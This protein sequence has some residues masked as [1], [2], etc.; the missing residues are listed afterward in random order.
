MVTQQPVLR[1]RGSEGSKH[2]LDTGPRPKAPSGTF[3]GERVGSA[4]APSGGAHSG[5]R[6]TGV[7]V[8]SGVSRGART[9]NPPSAAIRRPVAL[10]SD[11]R[12]S[13]L[14]NHAAP[15]RLAQATEGLARQR[16]GLGPTGDKLP[17]GIEQGDRRVV[18]P[19]DDIGPAPTAEL[20]RLSHELP[21]EGRLG[22][23]RL[24]ATLRPPR[25]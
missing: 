16:H 21:L 7:L 17:P 25:V 5:H 4:G 19:L 15:L 12:W 6:P 1:P 13:Q 11:E 23:W 20:S 24:P 3:L 9:W 22:P 8:L 18:V 10:V 2:P 14:V